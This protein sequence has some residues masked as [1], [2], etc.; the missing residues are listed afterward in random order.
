MT[1]LTETELVDLLDGVLPSARERH[2]D[3]CDA[4]RLTAAGMRQALTRAGEVEMGEPSPLFWEHFSARVHEGVRAAQPDEPWSWFGWA[5]GATVKWAVAGAALTLLLV[6]GV[7]RA[8]APVP[9]RASPAAAA[10]VPAGAPDAG[11]DRLDAFDPETDEAWALVRALADDVEWDDAQGNDAA[12]DG[13]DVRAGSVEHAMVTL[14][15]AERSEL[16]RLLEAAT[17][18]PGA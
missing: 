13:F 14:T 18:Q 5:Q 16:V 4:C 8:T 6:A 12:A 7:W 1:H 10:L 11:L 15:G 2:L 17:R 9:Q 3:G